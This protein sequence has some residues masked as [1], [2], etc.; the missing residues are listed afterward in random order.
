M[1]LPR[2]YF[3]DKRPFVSGKGNK[4]LNL[5]SSFNLNDLISQITLNTAPGNNQL[6]LLF[7]NAITPNYVQGQGTYVQWGGALVQDTTVNGGASYYIR[8]TNLSNFSASSQAFSTIFGTVGATI[9]GGTVEVDATTEYQLRTPNVNSS[10]AANGQILQLINSSS[11]S[12]QAEWTPFALPLIDGAANQVLV[13]DGL[14]T[15]TWKNV[16]A[17]LV[18]ADNGLNVTGTDVYFGGTLLQNT[19]VEG[20]GNAYN[21]GF[22]GMDQF[23]TESNTLNLQAD[24]QLVLQSPNVVSTTAVTGSVLQLENAATGEAEYTSYGIPTTAPTTGDILVATSATNVGFQAQYQ[25]VSYHVADSNVDLS[26]VAGVAAGERF[27]SIPAYMNGWKFHSITL[28]NDGTGG[29][30]TALDYSVTQNGG[31]TLT[32]DSWGGGHYEDDTVIVH[33]V[34]T[35]DIIKFDASSGGTN[36]LGLSITFTFKSN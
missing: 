27:M 31:T 9:G 24:T 22:V 12:G 7:N 2:E 18:G 17:T 34:S 11:L 15:V 13:T 36:L 3:I 30:V 25:S 1:A 14:G 26:T 4:F 5:A 29:A 19:E 28:V 16:P 32:S 8:M 21:I 20:D 6:P 35:G 10:S 23:Y 33:T